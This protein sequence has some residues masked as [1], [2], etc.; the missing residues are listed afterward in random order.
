MSV[1]KY[2]SPGECK[3]TGNLEDDPLRVLDLVDLLYL[4]GSPREE[5]PS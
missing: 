3:N 2:K 1:D 4:G 5:L